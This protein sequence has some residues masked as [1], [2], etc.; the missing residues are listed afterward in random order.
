MPWWWLLGCSA[1]FSFLAGSSHRRS[2]WGGEEEEEE[3]ATG[4]L[5]PLHDREED[6]GSFLSLGNRTLSKLTKDASFCM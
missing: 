4:P 6:P 2:G 5:S 3:K 1:L